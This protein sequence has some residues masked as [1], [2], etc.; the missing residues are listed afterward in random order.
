MTKPLVEVA[1]PGTAPA[2]IVHAYAD[3]P[4]IEACGP[5]LGPKDFAPLLLRVPT[6]PGNL[7]NV[8]P[9]VRLHQLVS[10][11]QL[12][13]PTKPGLELATTIDLILRQSYVK[14][15][16]RDPAT[17]SYV[18]GIRNPADTV[19]PSLLCAS[20]I[21]VSGV[22]KSVACERALARYP[23][24][25]E[26]PDFPH[27]V[28]KLRQLIW[29]KVN[30]PA[31]GKLEHLAR[32]LL[33]ATYNALGEEHE[34]ESR[35]WQ[36]QR[37]PQLWREW[38][39]KATSAFLGVLV[40]DEIQNFF[41]LESIAKRRQRKPG[42]R[43]IELRLVEDQ[44]LKN[45]LTL[46]NEGRIAVVALGTPDG[47][48]AFSK[49]FSTAQR[50]AQSGHHFFPNI[51]SPD[52]LFYERFL[53]PRLRQYVWADKPLENSD[54]IR[55]VVHR[56]SGGVLR[57]IFALWVF[58]HRCM[59]ERNGATLEVSDFDLAMTKYLAPLVPAVEALTSGDP[60]RLS[61]YEDLLPSD[62]NFFLALNANLA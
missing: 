62:F 3:N 28:S 45:I 47:M 16:P 59:W 26:H 21:G 39:R 18:Y 60:N 43:Q 22:G 51:K 53:F 29:L 24:V 1:S 7:T 57:I 58:A 14:R 52:D 49:R 19:D 8:P 11:L 13:I 25:V 20:A 36:K 38:E 31:S 34:E 50:L 23:Q 32:D 4:L 41:Q 40:L 44:T 6:A 12:H 2:S 27:M 46:S 56:H 54:A 9:H 37:G 10:V 48:A 55:A 17:W 42:D 30:V 33:Y 35:G 5:L 15:R 61:R